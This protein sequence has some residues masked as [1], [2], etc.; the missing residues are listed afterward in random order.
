MKRKILLFVVSFIF[1]SFN[2][3]SQW[4]S[5]GDGSSFTL[6]DLV[7]VSGG[8]VTMEGDSYYFNENITISTTDTLHINNDGI[9]IINS[10]KLWTIE[11]VLLTYPTNQF[12]IKNP[13]GEANFQGIR[14]DNSSASRLNNLMIT[15]CG[16][17]K[18]VDSHMEIVA[19]TFSN[20]GQEYSTGA[21]NLYQSNPLIRDCSFLSN[22][23][24]AIASG[25]N[26]DSSP[27]IIHNILNANVTSNSNT[28]Q[29]NLGTSNA[30]ESIIIDSNQVIG[31]YEMAGGIAVATLAGGNAN[32]TITN[33]EISNNRYGI[34]MI[35]NDINSIISNN[36]IVGNNI[37]GD[38]ML[39]GSG[40]NFY[41]GLTN[42]SIVSNNTISDNLWGITIQ[43]S[44][45]PNFGD[46]SEQS[47]GENII[48]DNQN[49]FQIYGLYNNTPNEIMA[50][51]NYW[52]TTDLEVA[53]TYIVHEVDD[54]T[55]G[56]VHFDPMW[57]NPVG[58]SKN[59]NSSAFS[60]YPNPCNDYFEINIP[61]SSNM[62]YSVFNIKG[63]IIESG[64]I[65]NG[66]Q[67]LSTTE[68]NRG[69]Y[70]VRLNNGIEVIVK[71]LMVQ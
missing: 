63:Q 7:T 44:A 8:V 65:V 9:L 40:L 24:P 57:L 1:I 16:G 58:L 37:Q 70:F 68:W 45:Q 55:L 54:A 6:D 20:F 39:G 50:I 33:N 11:G 38:P 28:P 48:T 4:I 36:T 30:I 10:E 60:V 31:A 5:P 49:N 21:I 19:S 17:I 12:E 51:N 52:G 23:G 3:Y 29:I 35:G 27:K 34:A 66:K 61:S 26:S 13:L 2:S 15:G 71:K 32:A 53:E 69:T 64:Q 59:T 47:P 14:F 46:G 25:A 56:L 41:G 42:T 18:L 22:A 43:S 62:S 67:R